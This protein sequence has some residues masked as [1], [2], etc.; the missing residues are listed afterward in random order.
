MHVT[1]SSADPGMLIGRGDVTLADLI[2]AS[3]DIDGLAG[4]APSYISAGVS[5][6]RSGRSGAV[7]G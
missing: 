4:M 2:M 5:P 3:A 7:P 6:G 1:D